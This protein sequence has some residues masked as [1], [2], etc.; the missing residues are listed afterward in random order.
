MIKKPSARALRSLSRSISRPSPSE[1]R[2]ELKLLRRRRTGEPRNVHRV[3]RHASCVREFC[4]ISCSAAFIPTRRTAV[5]SLAC[6]LA[7]IHCSF[8]R[9]LDHRRSNKQRNRSGE[10]H[11]ELRFPRASWPMS[12]FSPTR[13]PPKDPVVLLSGARNIATHLPKIYTNL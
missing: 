4:K 13:L 11:P 8:G 6:V 1:G 9:A 3:G 5:V 2:R 12:I 10:S 7:E